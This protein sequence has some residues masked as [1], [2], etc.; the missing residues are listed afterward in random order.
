MLSANWADHLPKTKNTKVSIM[1]IL[2]LPSSDTLKVGVT[3]RQKV[4]VDLLSPLG[5]G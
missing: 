1:K 3:V 5:H 4:R 2:R